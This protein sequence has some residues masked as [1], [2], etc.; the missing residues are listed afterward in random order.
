MIK[1]MSLGSG[2][3]GNSYFLQAGSTRLLIDAGISPR[4]M[5]KHLKG[6]SVTLEEIDAVFVTHDH[7]DHIKA[8]GFLANDLG[9]PVY[10]T[11][12]VHQGINR[13]FCVNGKLE[14][15]HV[16]IIQKNVPVQVGEFTITAFD[17]PHDSTDCVGYRVE[18]E[19]VTFCLLTDV[20]HVTPILQE[21]VSMANYIVLESN[22][23][24][25]MLMMGKYP[26]YLKGRIRGPKGHLSNDMS[27]HLLAEHATPRLKHVWLC[28]LSEENNHPE[29]ARK[30]MEGVCRSYGILPGKDFAMDILKRKTPSEL[31]ELTP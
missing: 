14:T 15:E 10:T 6:V 8:I 16:R 4:I 9:K 20:G 25:N 5:K 21:Q 19:G 11:E 29:L 18:A 7:A 22:H 13:N 31:Y 17:V 12:L 2:S 23:D 27:A 30:T 28:H 26:A 1:F 3:S 24:E